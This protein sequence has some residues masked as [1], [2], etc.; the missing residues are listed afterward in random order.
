MLSCTERRH[1]PEGRLL[2]CN[3]SRHNF[4]GAVQRRLGGRRAQRHV[5]D[6]LESP[7]VLL[8]LMGRQLARPRASSGEED[9]GPQCDR[10]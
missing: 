6:G 9:A 10:Q 8:L 3:L 2:S 1:L 7:G 4:L 5:G